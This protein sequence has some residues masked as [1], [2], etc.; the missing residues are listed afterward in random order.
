MNGKNTSFISHKQFFLTF[1]YGICCFFENISF[2]M[3][4]FHSR[5]EKYCKKC[6]VV[7]FKKMTS[8]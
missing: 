8:R 6:F 2:R 7:H 3:L 1:V 5:L 4:N